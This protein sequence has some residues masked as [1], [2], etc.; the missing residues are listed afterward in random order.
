VTY[1]TRN[2]GIS[3]HFLT[4]ATCTLTCVFLL[5]YQS[6]NHAPAGS[7]PGVI[8]GGMRAQNAVL[9]DNDGRWMVRKNGLRQRGMPCV[10][11]RMRLVKRDERT[12]MM[13]SSTL[14]RRSDTHVGVHF[15]RRGGA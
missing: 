15:E 1:P 14:H 11:G 13:A 6:V 8:C 5:S 7:Y 3:N 12:E 4:A 10:H 9:P 2:E